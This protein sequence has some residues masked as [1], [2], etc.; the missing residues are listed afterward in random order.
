[1]R[2]LYIFTSLLLLSFYGFSQGCDTLHCNTWYSSLSVNQ[3]QTF[4]MPA[5]QGVFLNESSSVR[6]TIDTAYAVAQTVLGYGNFTSGTC[7]SYTAN[8]LSG[9]SYVRYYVRDTCGNQ[10]SCNAYIF[11]TCPTINAV[12]DNFAVYNNVA[13]TP[14]D[15]SA[16]DNLLGSTVDTVIILNGPTNGTATVM[17]NKII[18]SGD[19][20]Y[21]GADQLDYR[22]C[23]TCGK[24]D[25]ATLFLSVQECV[26]LEAGNDTIVLTQGDAITSNIF[27]N[28][29]N[30][31][32][33][34]VSASI[35]SAPTQGTASL[36]DSILSYTSSQT[37]F[38]L[39]VLQYQVCTPCG[40]DTATVILNI[41]Q[42]PCSKPTANDD[43]RY[44]GFA[45]GATSTYNVLNNDVNPIGGGA[46]SLSVVTQP[47]WGTVTVSGN[48]LVYTV[49]D[50][51]H[52]GDTTSFTYAMCNQCFCDTASV[53]LAISQY[54]YNG[55]APVANRDTITL[56]RNDSTYLNLLVNDFDL[57]GS[58][59]TLTDSNTNSLIWQAG[60]G[61]VTKVDSVTLLYV[62]I[63]NYFGPDI[64]QYIIKDY[65]RPQLYGQAIVFVNVDFCSNAPEITENGE[66]VEGL[67]VNILKDSTATICLEYYDVNGDSVTVFV[68]NSVSNIVVNPSTASTQPCLTITPPA[69]YL[70]SESVWVK[71]CDQDQ[72]CD[73]VLLTI[74]VT[75]DKAPPLANTDFLTYNWTASCSPVNVLTNDADSDLGDAVTLTS[76][77]S[78]SALGGTV[79]QVGD[80]SLCYSPLS[81][82]IGIDTV[83]YVVCDN[84][85]LCATGLVIVNVT[86]NAIS[87]SFNINQEQESTF[88]VKANDSRFDGEE[89]EICANPEHGT[90]RIENG[91][92]IYK[93][94]DDYPYDP[95][96]SN[97]IGTGVDSFCYS[98]C[99]TIGSERF[100]DQAI[101]YIT[102]NPKSSF[103]IPNGFSP[104]GDGINDNFVIVST[105]EYPD[106]QLIVYNRY[107]DEV[108]RN[109]GGGYRNDFNGNFKRNQKT[110]PDGTYF[111]IFKFN[112]GVTKDKTDYIIINR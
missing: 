37:Y 107:G 75:T 106:A 109:D 38:G 43:F 53:T 69:N 26:K 47:D 22:V 29:A 62:P 95:I 5:N 17:N 27:L 87:D 54:R 49:S 3:T 58:H 15:V 48:N 11:I 18:Y 34:Y 50:S 88:D 45:T 89:L 57:E 31:L 108:W 63:A 83:I 92:I 111:Y 100:C 104:N 24:C 36:S 97:E 6:P 76:F 68:G 94:M 39:D 112:D 81:T 13:N 25:S 93:P 4:C 40:C 9:I 21:L 7:M 32:L 2:K 19:G 103:F 56:C 71:I 105:D 51:T 86:I 23:N 12:N 79:T 28:D 14:I 101:V 85:G 65:D 67:T 91:N 110:L 61:F 82:F 16:N 84:Y 98:L 70:G 60:H 90:V 46:V 35:I 96:I 8:D 33:G 20:S 74:N 77:I 78:P 10:K 102:I 52:S 73:S 59:I 41:A 55:S 66:V 80:S 44:S 30:L 64:F 72:L 1:M 42:A 99:K